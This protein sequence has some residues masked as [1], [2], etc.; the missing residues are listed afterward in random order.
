V[1]PSEI[2]VCATRWQEEVAGDRYEK[3]FEEE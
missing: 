3:A 2:A 1:T